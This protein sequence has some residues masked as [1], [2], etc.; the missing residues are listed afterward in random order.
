MTFYNKKEDVIDIKLTQFGKNLL[1][2]GA[3]KPAY[4]AFFDD[5]II[6]EAAAGF[7]KELQNNSEDRIRDSIR[8]QT[9]YVNIGIETRFDQ[10][11]KKIEKGDSSVYKI[12]QRKQNPLEKE[13]LLKYPLADKELGTQKTPYF[14]V[15][16]LGSEITGSVT[17]LIEKVSNPSDLKIKSPTGI[18]TST[19]Q[20]ATKPFVNLKIDYS[21]IIEPDAT[22]PSDFTVDLLADEITYPNGIRIKKEEA[23]IILDLQEFGVPH[24]QDN[25]EI[26]IFEFIEEVASTDDPNTEEDEGLIL[27]RTVKLEDNDQIFELF[28]I[29]TDSSVSV[30]DPEQR[31][32]ERRAR[33]IY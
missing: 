6:Y 1:S 14:K 27:T 32:K 25:F 4:Y 31:A 5:D 30:Y 18:L 15:A 13:K 21:R 26:E 7:V 28:D 9:P 22:T 16:F 23:N 20:I 11:T 3:F 19:P 12:I 29:F 17:K 24:L 2:R 8:L 33:T 10:E